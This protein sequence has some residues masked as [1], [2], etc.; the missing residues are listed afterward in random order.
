MWRYQRRDDEVTVVVCRV[1]HVFPLVTVF[2]SGHAVDDGVATRFAGVR[3]NY[4]GTLEPGNV[5]QNFVGGDWVV[6]ADFVAVQDDSVV[7]AADFVAVRDAIACG[8]PIRKSGKRQPKYNL[9][10]RA[11]EPNSYRSTRV[12]VQFD[13]DPQSSS[14]K[15]VCSN[16]MSGSV[17]K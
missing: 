4:A 3:R 14:L 9:H 17:C 16:A 1:G 13:D 15:I 12:G 7:V 11:I 8:A 2:L 10:F 6:V 5:A